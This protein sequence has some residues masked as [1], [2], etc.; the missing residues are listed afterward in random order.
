MAEPSGKLVV[1]IAVIVFLRVTIE[2]SGLL[3]V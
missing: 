1:G 3:C 2:P